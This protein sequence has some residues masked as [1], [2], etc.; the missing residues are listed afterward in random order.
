MIAPKTPG[1]PSHQGIKDTRYISNSIC[2][3]LEHYLG[4]LVRPGTNQHRHGRVQNAESSCGHQH[5]FASL[6]AAPRTR[7]A[8]DGIGNSSQHHLSRSCCRRQYTEHEAIAHLSQPSACIHALG[9]SNASRS[10]I[11][12][13]C[14]IIKE[15]EEEEDWRDKLHAKKSHSQDRQ[16]I[17]G[18][19]RNQRHEELSAHI[20]PLRTGTIRP[21]ADGESKMAKARTAPRRLDLF[22]W[23]Q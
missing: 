17:T 20:L 23:G 13:P 15:E 1:R 21:S 5:S 2:K 6:P 10:Q 16:R 3:S 18:G 14:G 12:Y 19:G 7:I 8:D 22:Q 11:I 4:T 9:S